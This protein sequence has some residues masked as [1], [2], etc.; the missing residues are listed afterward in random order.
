[1]GDPVRL[2]QVI[3]NLVGNAIKFTKDGE[4]SLHVEN[5]PGTNQPGTNESATLLF[6]VCDTGIGIHLEKMD[7][8]F[9][10]FTQVDASTSREFGGTGL[11]LAICQRL[12]GLM[13]GRI[14]VE[15]TAG[16][17]S[18]F[19]FT[20]RFGTPG[21]SVNSTVAQLEAPKGLKT[22]V[23]DDNATNRWVLTQMLAGWGASVVEA[24][25]GYQALAELDRASK[26]D[27]PY[28]LLL[29]DG[30]VPGMDGFQL[31]EHI[32]QYL[33]APDIAILM[34]TSENRSG[35]LALCWE[36]GVS[37][38]LI[39]PVKRAELLRAISAAWSSDRVGINEPRALMQ[40][41]IPGDQRSLR[42]LLAEDSPDNRLLIQSYLKNTAYSIEIAENGEVALG[43]YMA[44]NYDLILMDIQMP[45]MDGYT[46]TT[47]IR[48]WEKGRETPPTPIIALTAHAFAEDMQRSRD[49][50]CTAHI[51]KPINKQVLIQAIQ[52]LTGGVAA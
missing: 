7:S 45:V 36:R 51:T 12:I 46:A 4:V 14:W 10:R 34:L 13:G 40:P 52:E 28:Q 11:G 43:K 39:K 19:C 42:I 2:G 35:D 47:A 49:V 37:R 44:G 9:D 17:G 21:D 6:R 16:Q 50:G 18:T 38:Y 29:L 41:A 8:I 31:I 30:R 24:E 15:S 23:V 22:L 27:T 32:K 3:T 1:M 20:A 26:T 33:G 25:D 5:E 48:E